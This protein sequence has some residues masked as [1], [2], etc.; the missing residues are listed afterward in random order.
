MPCSHK[1][2]TFSIALVRQLKFFQKHKN[3]PNT[4]GNLAKSTATDARGFRGGGGKVVSG[5]KFIV[6]TKSY[7]EKRK[8]ILLRWLRMLRLPPGEAE[9]TLLLMERPKKR[10]KE[11]WLHLLSSITAG[12]GWKDSWSLVVCSAVKKQPS[13][14]LRDKELMICISHWDGMLQRM[15]RV[16]LTDFVKNKVH[17]DPPTALKKGRELISGAGRCREFYQASLHTASFSSSV[18]YLWKW[19]SGLLVMKFLF[20]HK[21]GHDLWSGSR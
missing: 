9:Q 16:K 11:S 7:K 5:G 12:G 15:A 19:S 2:T 13:E 14:P 4:L 10:S 8:R 18:K 1:R 6:T 17:P 20:S 3:I 21:E